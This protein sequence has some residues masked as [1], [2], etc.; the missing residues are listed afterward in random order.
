MRVSRKIIGGFLI[1][2]LFS[3]SLAHS[4]MAHSQPTAGSTRSTQQLMVKVSGENRGAAERALEA[5]NNPGSAE[6]RLRQ[7]QAGFPSR[8]RFL[9]ESRVPPEWRNKGDPADRLHGWLVLHYE[10]VD[11]AI[12][13]RKVIAANP[14]VFAAVQADS[15]ANG[16]S[17]TPTDPLYQHSVQLSTGVAGTSS[18]AAHSLLGLP[19]AWNYIHGTAYVANLDSGIQVNHEDLNNNLRVHFSASVSSIPSIDESPNSGMRGHG[20]Y[21]AGV[22]AA[23]PNN[24]AGTSGVCWN[25]SLMSIRITNDERGFTCSTAI[26]GMYEAINSGAQ[27]FNLSLFLTDQCAGQHGPVEDAIALAASRQVSIAAA[28]GNNRPFVTTTDFPATNPYVM[29]VAATLATGAWAS[30]SNVGKIDFAA[31]GD[32]VHSTFYSMSSWSTENVA[33]AGTDCRADG[34]ESAAPYH[35]YGFCT[36]TSV[37]SPMIA[38]SA[39]LVRSANPLLSDAAVK[40]YLTAYANRHG[41]SS[42][43]VGAGVPNVGASVYDALYGTAGNLGVTPF[44]VLHG[45]SPINRFYTTVPQ[46]ASSAIAFGL[47]HGSIA[48]RGVFGYTPAAG[49]GSAVSGYA[50]PGTAGTPVAA[51]NLLTTVNRYGHATVPLYRFSYGD[52]SLQAIHLYDTNPNVGSGYVRDGIEGYVYPVSAAQPPGTVRLIRKY[53]P[54]TNRWALFPESQL[55]YFTSIGFTAPA[56]NADVLGY[57]CPHPLPNAGVCPGAAN[58]TMPAMTSGTSATFNVGQYGAFTFT[59]SG[60]PAPSITLGGALPAGVSFTPATG[61]ATLAGTPSSGTAGSYPLTV[62]ASSA[63]GVVT[64]AF[65]LTVAQTSIPFVNSGMESPATT[66]VGAVPDG[67]ISNASR[68]NGGTAANAFLVAYGGQPAPE[69]SQVAFM[70]PGVWIGQYMNLAAGNY[71]VVFQAGTRGIDAPQAVSVWLNGSYL[72]QFTTSPTGWNT[73]SIAI[74]GLWAGNHLFQF[75]NA[76]GTY[77]ILLLDN[78]RMTS[79]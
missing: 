45:G 74:P 5:L 67:W 3:L 34:N 33:G 71:T 77:G 4:G 17:V 32:K 1:G 30:W 24:G 75:A 27:V 13:A 16:F 36:G 25:C 10:S 6:H 60:T 20:T 29:S 64:Q 50:F 62:T 12:A 53:N 26:A 52:Y 65:T 28:A 39:A 18:F 14:D 31:P 37:S 42:F 7:A 2:S 76:S 22:I 11:S 59:A 41:A 19:S 73:Y 35:H 46:M 54:G 78:V 63:M 57:V 58:Y 15:R 47:K 8:A 43:Y 9:I 48:L 70:S 79:P 69:G 23:T 56:G 61:S 66:W 44:F 38:G 72:V 68:G 49:E 51:V 55:G 40:N 21:T